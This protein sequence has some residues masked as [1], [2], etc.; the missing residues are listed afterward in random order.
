MNC[1]IRHVLYQ[2]GKMSIEGQA[3]DAHLAGLVELAELAAR[4]VGY[5]SNEATSPPLGVTA[6]LHATTEIDVVTMRTLPS[7]R[8]H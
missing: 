4:K 8:R 7:Q 2:A 5:W 6:A 3:S 1:D